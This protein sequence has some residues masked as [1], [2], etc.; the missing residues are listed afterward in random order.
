MD[1]PAEVMWAD[2]LTKPLQETVFRKMT[3]QLMNCAMEY[4]DGEEIPT[5][6]RKTQLGQEYQQDMIQTFQE[7]VG[8]Y[9]RSKLGT[10]RVINTGVLR[11]TS[12]RRTGMRTQ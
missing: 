6:K 7:C 10:R 11:G 2:V 12:R 3:A 4:I 1:C 8:R 9:N 5:K